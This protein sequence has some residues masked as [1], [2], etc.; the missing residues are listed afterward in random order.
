[1]KRLIRA[2][3]DVSDLRKKISEAL[4]DYIRYELWNQ[5]DYYKQIRKQFTVNGRKYVV[6]N[7][8][9]GV[10]HILDPEGDDIYGYRI[11]TSISYDITDDMALDIVN[12]AFSG[13][14]DIANKRVPISVRVGHT[15]YGSN[16]GGVVTLG[17]YLDDLRKY[18]SD[19]DTTGR[20]VATTIKAWWSND[21]EN[22]KW[23][24]TLNEAVNFAQSFISKGAHT[25]STEGSMGETRY[26]YY[27]NVI[28]SETGLELYYDKSASIPLYK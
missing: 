12:D 23:F 4:Y 27:A 10:L 24:D 14:V 18:Y 19:G 13:D 22:C 3:K 21:D 6:K 7:D 8:A 28:D 5:R 16:S 25:M 1:M 20:Y 17:R 26:H 2:T 11:P 15:S 9:K